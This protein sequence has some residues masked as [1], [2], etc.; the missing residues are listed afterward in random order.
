MLV[1]CLLLVMYANFVRNY[2]WIAAVHSVSDIM[3][4]CLSRKNFIENSSINSFERSY[5]SD[6]EMVTESFS[7]PNFNAFSSNLMMRR[8]T[9][10][11]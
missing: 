1:D 9:L 6:V 5:P 2:Y 7:I 8:N 11:G 4:S 10:V 3:V